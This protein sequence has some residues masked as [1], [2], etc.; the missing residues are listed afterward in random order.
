MSNIEIRQDIEFLAGRLPHRGPNTEQERTAAEYIQGRLR[1]FIPDV[2]LDDFHSFESNHVLFASYYAEFTVVALL[3]H[4]SPLMALCYG[5]LVFL[6]YLGEFLGY[7]IFSRLLPQFESQNVVARILAARPKRLLVLSAHYDSPRQDFSTR[8]P[9]LPWIRPIHQG[10]VAA[11]T[12]VLITCATSALGLF[13]NGPLPVN[14]IARWSAAGLLLAA[15]FALV[16]NS[17]QDGFSRGANG[18][19]S[20]VAALLSLAERLA[21]EPLA[22]TDVWLV[23]TGSKCSWMNGM[24]HLLKSHAF[25]SETTY[26]VNIEHVGIGHPHYVE[27]EGVLSRLHSSSELLAMARAAATACAAQSCQHLP[28]PTDAWIPLGRGYKAIT[29]AAMEEDTDSK[30]WYQRSDTLAHVDDAAIR[31]AAG[32][33]E[34][35]CRTLDTEGPSGCSPG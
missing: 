11:M 24:H 17:Q 22:E 21:A 7:H 34:A 15:A 9:I 5:A 3:A 6:T 13:A 33:V 2:V 12:V 20:G 28:I 31:S 30:A 23:A 8:F 26:F 18:N 25:D 4:W 14:A 1:Q 27:T 29:I 35:L 19:A 16:Y 32:F 10:L